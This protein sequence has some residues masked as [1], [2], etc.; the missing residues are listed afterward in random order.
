V[1]AV[2]ALPRSLSLWLV[3]AERGV[4]IRV[5]PATSKT[6]RTC[7]PTRL[8]TRIGG[9]RLEYC[10]GAFCLFLFTTTSPTAEETESL[11]VSSSGETSRKKRRVFL[12][13]P[14]HGR[15]PISLRDGLAALSAGS[16]VSEVRLRLDVLTATSL[17]RIQAGMG[18][19]QTWNNCG[20]KQ[21]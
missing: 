9:L 18:Y 5:I 21:A 19:R 16:R 2:V 7:L 8:H 17:A 12:Q 15:R 3:L 6:A 10:Y 14:I 11:S 20:H 13:N 1:E 4:Y